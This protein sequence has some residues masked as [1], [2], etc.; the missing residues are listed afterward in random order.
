MSHDFFHIGNYQPCPVCN[1]SEISFGPPDASGGE[2]YKID[3]VYCAM[4]GTVFEIANFTEE[5]VRFAKLKL[6]WAS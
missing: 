3:A 5:G 1:A 4:C 2:R 6:V